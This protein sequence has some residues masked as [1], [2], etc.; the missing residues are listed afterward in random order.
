MDT[1]RNTEEFNC[2]AVKN[3]REKYKCIYSCSIGVNRFP[4]R[5]LCESFSVETVYNNL[6]I[7]LNQLNHAEK[8]NNQPPK[9]LIPVEHILTFFNWIRLEKF[10]L[11]HLQP[12]QTKP[13]AAGI[14]GPK[15][16]QPKGT[17]QNRE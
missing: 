3:T 10:I 14:F 12:N 1:V 15:R 7:R 2:Y 4:N 13:V 5:T 9:R 8:K 17:F 11:G 6:P 16:T